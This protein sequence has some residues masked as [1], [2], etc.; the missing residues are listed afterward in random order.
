MLI[1]RLGPSAAPRRVGTGFVP[2]S[3]CCTAVLSRI[4]IVV[5]MLSLTMSPAATSCGEPGVRFVLTAERLGARFG[6]PAAAPGDSPLAPASYPAQGAAGSGTGYGA[7]SVR[8]RVVATSRITRA[9]A[10]AARHAP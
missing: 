5:S 4:R 10:T 9:S 6:R 1:Y 2:F 8:L 3:V 7:T